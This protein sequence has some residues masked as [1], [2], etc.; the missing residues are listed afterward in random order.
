MHQN[1]RC[2]GGCVLCRTMLLCGCVV[3]AVLCDD[4][5]SFNQHLDAEAVRQD[6]RCA[7][8]S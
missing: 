6:L 1:I 8:Q 4:K 7:C 3:C 2:L 5:D